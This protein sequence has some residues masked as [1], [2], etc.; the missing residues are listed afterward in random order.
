MVP[1]YIAS[2]H[3]HRGINIL[4][5]NRMFRILIVIGLLLSFLNQ[6]SNASSFLQLNTLEEHPVELKI[7]TGWRNHSGQQSQHIFGLKLDLASGWKTYWRSPGE[8]GIAP[9]IHWVEL[10]N[11]SNPQVHFPEPRLIT[12]NYSEVS[13]IGY[14]DNV[15]FPIT[16]DVIDADHPVFVSGSLDLGICRDVCIPE[17]IDFN[18]ELSANLDIM[19]DSITAAQS[20]TPDKVDVTTE[21]FHFICRIK[22]INTNEYSLLA[23]IRTTIK[24]PTEYAVAIEY[25]QIPVWFGTIATELGGDGMMKLNTHITDPNGQFRVI[26]RSKLNAVV[27]TKESATEYSGCKGSI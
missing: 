22:P 7:L 11:A 9:K 5:R 8:L 4:Q 14:I 6:S 27:V 21:G 19:I 18:A 25:K 17:S 23:E 20:S 24:P 10:A 12:D 1:V 13:I 26:D 3:C 15:I 2:F 16:V